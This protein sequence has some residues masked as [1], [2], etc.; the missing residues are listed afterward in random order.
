MVEITIIKHIHSCFA[1]VASW[2]KWVK[3][4]VDIPIPPFVGLSIHDD[5][6]E[7]EIKSV[8]IDSEAGEINCY[9]DPDIELYD[10]HNP[11]DPGQDEYRKQRVAEIQQEYIKDGWEEG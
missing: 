11:L 6:F 2:D 3:R 7:A 5:D 4:T 8:S 1:A 9:T 10:R